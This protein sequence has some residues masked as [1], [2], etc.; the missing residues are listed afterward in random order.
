LSGD[1]YFDSEQALAA[2]LVDTITVE[3]SP[4]PVI[5][6]AETSAPDRG[7]TDDERLFSAML[8]AL[9]E[10]RVRSKADFCRNLSAYVAYS[11]SELG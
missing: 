9:G 3:Q 1:T 11:V 8:G 10:I 4:A 7:P 6:Q 2:G 5:A